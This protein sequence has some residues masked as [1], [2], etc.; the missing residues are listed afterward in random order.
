MAYSK[1]YYE[2]HKEQMKRSRDKYRKGTKEALER[3]RKRN[4]DRYNMLPVEKKEQLLKRQKEKREEKLELTR[5]QY[6][7]DQKKKQ[8]RQYN[9]AILEADKVKLEQLTAKIALKTKEIEELIKEK[10]NL[11]V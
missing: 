1:E 3:T 5:L 6:R 8:I 10:E 4:R 2:M 9:A 7:I 11:N